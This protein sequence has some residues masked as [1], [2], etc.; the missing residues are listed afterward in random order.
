[1]CANSLKQVCQCSIRSSEAKEDLCL[2]IC[3]VDNYIWYSTASGSTGRCIISEFEIK[4]EQS[5][6]NK[7]T[8]EAWSITSSPAQPDVAYSSAD[9]GSIHIW[10]AR[11][12]EKATS[13]VKS[14]V[15]GVCSLSFPD[16]N[17]T[18]RL[19]SGGFDNQI[20]FWDTRVL[21]LP[22]TVSSIPYTVWN[23]K[24]F[25]SNQPTASISAMEQGNHC[26]MLD[27]DFSS[28][29]ECASY[30]IADSMVHC[31]DDNL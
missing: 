7:N 25:D 23:V 24:W 18:T 11:K 17:C 27:R 26:I 10:D 12:K 28:F 22:Q 15:Y 9:D 8:Y 1:A 5:F 29:S 4:P 3:V 21:K 2:S 31:S 20:C 14:H 6:K 19:C 13:F 30:E 16:K